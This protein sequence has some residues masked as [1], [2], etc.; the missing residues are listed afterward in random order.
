MSK[1]ADAKTAHVIKVSNAAAKVRMPAEW[2]KQQAVWISW[3]HDFFWPGYSLKLEGTYLR[4]I[5][6]MKTSQSVQ[7]LIP[8]KNYENHVEQQ[9]DFFKISKDNIFFHIIFTNDIWI[10]DF[11][12]TFVTQGSEIRAVKWGFN[13]YGERF[14]YNYAKSAAKSVA[15]KVAHQANIDYPPIVLEGGNIET[16]GEGTI[17]LTESAVFNPSRNPDTSREQIE[18]FLK[19]YLGATRI[20]WLSGMVTEDVEKTGW[21]DDTDSHVDTIARFTG[22]NT[23]VA[24]WT[25]D[26]SDPAYQLL[27]NTHRE[28]MEAG[29]EVINLPTIKVGFYSLTNIGEG[30]GV[31]SGKMLRTDASYANYVITNDK[32]IVPTYGEKEDDEAKEILRE[33]FPGREI[34]GLFGG[35]LAENGG[36][37]HCIT[38]Q[39]P[40]L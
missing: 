17:M 7:I 18:A 33:Q 13:G 16:N 3:P 22:K 11:G 38:Q 34:V 39:Q 6:L 12:P 9:L 1:K 15:I 10:R 8:N 37:F 5:E 20:I 25:T 27:K 31:N 35:L 23:V 29:L 21:S 2:E 4:L 30:G 26:K 19:E 24:P 28:L 36:E 14:K 32:V 40:A